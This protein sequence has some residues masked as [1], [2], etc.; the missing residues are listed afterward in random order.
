MSP[1]LRCS[2]REPRGFEVAVRDR[3]GVPVVIRNP[4]VLDDSTPMP[5][6]YWLV[7]RAE[8][9]AVSRLEAAGGVKEAEAAVD[10]EELRRHMTCTRPSAKPRSA[11]YTQERSPPAVSGEPARA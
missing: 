7:G 9:T 1:W 2:G 10:P 6:R 8:M 11:G 4:A 5:T 3:T